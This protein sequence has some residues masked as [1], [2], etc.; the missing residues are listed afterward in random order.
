MGKLKVR[1]LEDDVYQVVEFKTDDEDL[2]IY[3]RDN[4]EIAHQGSLSDCEAFIRLTE[5][6][7]M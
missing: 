4:F 7:Y 5:G 2:D 3:D 1:W 6:G